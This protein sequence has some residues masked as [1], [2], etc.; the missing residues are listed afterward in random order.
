MIKLIEDYYKRNRDKLIKIVRYRVHNFHDAEDIVQAAFL[1]AI[2]Y[3]DSFNKE[4]MQFEVWFGTILINAMKRHMKEQRSMG[5]YVDI[6]DAEEA[7][8]PVPDEN[9][10]NEIVREISDLI[11][12]YKGNQRYVTYLYFVKGYKL[13]DIAKIVDVPYKTADSILNRFKREVLGR[14]NADLRR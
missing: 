7:L 9:L 11:D 14:Y 12:T 3:S 13:A 6:E 4:I 1:N 10:D 2:T 8:P 5:T